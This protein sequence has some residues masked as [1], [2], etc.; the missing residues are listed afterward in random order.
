MIDAI[1]IDVSNQSRCLREVVI[2]EENSDMVAPHGIDGWI[3]APRLGIVYNVIMNKRRQVY[4]FEGD[5]QRQ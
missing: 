1:I 4:H 2:S 5:A 3:T